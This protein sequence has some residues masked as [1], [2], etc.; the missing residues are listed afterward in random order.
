MT[1]PSQNYAQLPE[2]GTALPR[3]GSADG[4]GSG[5]VDASAGQLATRLG[6]QLSRLVRDELALAQLEAKQRAKKMG[7]GAGMFGVSGLFAFFGACCAVAAAVIGLANVLRPWAAAIAVAIA[8]FLVAG[9]F[10]LPALKLLTSRRPAVPRDSID[11]VR[12]DVSAVKAAL[13]R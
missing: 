7:V 3:Q 13:H 4:S 10:G 12:A 9:L 2:P 8:A 11:S 5:D 1:T 6:E